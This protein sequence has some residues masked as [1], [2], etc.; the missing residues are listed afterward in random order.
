MNVL[1]FEK[2]SSK[3]AWKIRLIILGIILFGFTVFTITPLEIVQNLFEGNHLFERQESTCIM[4][5]IAGIPCPLCGMTRSYNEFRE[6]NISSG[7][8][9]NPLSVIVFPLIALVLA[10]ILLASLLNYKIKI[11]NHKLFWGSVFLLILVVWIVNIFWG[12]H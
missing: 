5:N 7:M 3:E 4:L 2:V 11:L 10:V 6:F 8:Y 1:T 12:H 9:Y